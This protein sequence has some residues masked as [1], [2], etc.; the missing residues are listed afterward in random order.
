MN[1]KAKAKLTG[2]KKGNDK[3]SNKALKDK[4]FFTKKSVWDGLVSSEEK[5][6]SL[7]SEKYKSFLNK[8]KTARESVLHLEK[9]AKDR[10]YKN[11][12]SASKNDKRLF[13][14]YRG[15][16]AVIANINNLDFEKGFNILASHIDSP[17]LDLKGVTLYESEDM[18]FMKT[19]YY[20]GIKKYQWV[21][22]PLAMHGVVL[23]SDG[24]MVNVVVGENDEDPVFTINDLLPHLAQEQ[25]LKPANKVIEGEQLNI[26]VGSIP[27]KF[28]SEKDAI[29]LN[30]LDHLNK[31]YGIKEEDFV[32]AELH[33]VPAGKARDVG[34]D[35]SFVGSHGQDDRVCSFT[36]AMAIFDAPKSN[37]NILGIFFDKEEIGSIGDGAADSNFIMR[38]FAKI[39]EHYGVKSSELM[40][41]VLENSKVISC[42]VIAGVDPEWRNT[43]DIMNAAKM[44]YGVT[45]NK[46]GGSR[47]KSGANE[48][49]ADFVQ[50]VRAAFEKEEIKWQVAELGKVDHGGGGT[51][52]MYFAYYG[53][54]VM[55]CGPALLS[56]HSTFEVA[57]KADIYS[58]YNAYKAFLKHC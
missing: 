37:K 47:G 20:G 55:D 57:S 9:M 48:T 7:F 51:V 10:S 32:S 34:F 23:K 38:I 6:I 54:D 52:A 1:K 41:K 45:I 13:I 36:S 31:T 18:A 26:L 12:R 53:M 3:D 21:T 11:I 2:S 29:K 25:I 39:M 16:S 5:D 4:L 8:C 27:Y 17:Q 42:D 15:V 19:H 40:L 50:S 14:N 35:R 33:L 58:T 30:I 44:G 56:M 43:M 24:K 46:Y 22:T 49:H 28:K